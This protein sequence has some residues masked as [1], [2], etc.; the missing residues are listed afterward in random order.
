LRSGGLK[1]EASPENILD[2]HHGKKR[3]CSAPTPMNDDGTDI[4]DLKALTPRELDAFCA[5][6]LGRKPGQGLRVAVLLYRKRL[7]NLDAMTD[8]N[9][10]FR[11]QLKRHCAISVLP[12]EKRGRSEDGVEKLL[13]R[14]K[15]GDSVEGAL[16]PGP[17]GRLTLCVS[18]QVGCASGCAFCL[19]GS[20]GLVRNLSVSE[21]VSQVF[22]AGRFAERPIT[23]IVLMGAG[24]PLANYDAVKNFVEIATDRNGMGFS[25]RKVTLS[26][27]GHAPR[28]MQLADDGVEASLAISLNATTDDVRSAVMPVNRT[29]P[30]ASLLEAARY[31]C[32]KT[33]RSV[34][35]EYVLLKNVNDSPDD[36]RRLTDLVQGLPCMINVL[37]FNA[38][39]GAP[40]E[41]PDEQCAFAFRKLLVAN[42]LVT[43]VRNSRGT[44]VGAACGQ[45]RAS[46]GG[47]EKRR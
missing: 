4:I 28:I 16:I 5:E 41:R 1:R 17:G 35:V 34:A 33:G 22:A 6:R 29:W 18:S 15:D 30:I 9:R 25:P 32:R 14:L 43:V 21:I 27:S 39:P 3:E 47:I 31:Y 38:F 10:S 45:L 24:E 19:T 20:A 37:L 13:Y 36:A 11:E 7:E 40:F 2:T 44:G 42:G 46:C 26:T 23:N 12:A 8:L